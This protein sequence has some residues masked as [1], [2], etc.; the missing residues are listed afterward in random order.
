M[1]KFLK[2]AESWFL[3]PYVTQ[4][5]CRDYMKYVNQML[6]IIMKANNFMIFRCTKCSCRLQDNK[7]SLYWL[8]T[9]Q[10]SGLYDALIPSM[11]SPIGVHWHVDKLQLESFSEVCLS[12]SASASVYQFHLLLYLCQIIKCYLDLWN[13]RVNRTSYSFRKLKV[14]ILKRF[15]KV[16]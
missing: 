11:N 4:S 13:V 10:F 15:N 16:K 3:L 6:V 2:L 9:N 7:S 1:W 14:N 8:P 12:V 5:C